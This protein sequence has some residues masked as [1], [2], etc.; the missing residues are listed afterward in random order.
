MSKT[1]SII[2]QVLIAI[3]LMGSF[4]RLIY[5]INKHYMDDI[6]VSGIL[7]IVFGIYLYLIKLVSKHFKKGE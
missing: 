7:I 5:F 6:I 3:S 1:E 2:L 4:I